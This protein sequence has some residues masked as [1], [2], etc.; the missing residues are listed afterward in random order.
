VS[1]LTNGWALLI[2]IDQPLP[3]RTAMKSQNDLL[4]LPGCVA[5][6]PSDS[7][8]L[9]HPTDLHCSGTVAGALQVS[10]ITVAPDDR[11]CFTIH[12]AN[13]RPVITFCFSTFDAAFGAARNM[14]EM[15]PRI[16]HAIVGPW[17]VYGV[18]GHSRGEK[19]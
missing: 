12:K 11:Y 4:D 13:G 14:V 8:A 6:T 3:I 2:L 10:D 15:L 5:I 9:R 17:K 7:Q 1:S 18:R 19:G 16:A